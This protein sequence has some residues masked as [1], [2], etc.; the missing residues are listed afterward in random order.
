MT[1]AR[2]NKIPIWGGFECS[3]V[4]IGEEYRDQLGETGHGAREKDLDILPRLGLKTV[5]HGILWEHVAPDEPGQ[6]NWQ[7]SDTRLRILASRGITPIVGLLHHGSGP[8]YTHLLDPDFPQRLA[9]YARSV[10]RRYP[11]LTKFT[12][13]NEPGTTARFSCLYGHWFPHRRDTAAFLRALFLQVYG[14]ALAMRAIREITPAAE[15]IQT[16]E[17]GRVFSTPRLNYQAA[18]ENERRWLSLDLLCGRVDRAHGWH[19][20]FRTAGIAA[21]FL[22]DLVK[23]PSPPNIVGINYYLSSDRFLDHRVG[24]YPA[25]CRGGNGRHTYVDSEAIRAPE[26][27]ADSNLTERLLE[28]WARYNIPV[29]V[30]E[31]H[32]GCTRE[33]QIRWLVDSYRA[34]ERAQMLGVD[35]RGV[36]VW[37]LAGAVDWNSLLT[38]RASCYE[39]GVLEVSG[40]PVRITAM[41]RA[42]RELA[43]SGSYQHHLLD[44]P[45]WW[46]RQ[47]RFNK[48]PV[49]A[50]ETIPG[51]PL[52]VVGPDGAL[53]QAFA[54]LCHLRNLP[55]RL[56][57]PQEIDLV[58][59]KAVDGMIE[60]ERP[61]AIV[62]ITG[63]DQLFQN[64]AA[65]AAEILARASC[66]RSVPLVTFSS[67]Q[68]FDGRLGRPYIETD[69]TTPANEYGAGIVS[70]E[71]RV[72]ECHPMGMIV[73]TS[74]FFGPWN[75]HNFVHSVL[76]TLKAGRPVFIAADA[77]ISPTYLPDLV[78]RTLDLLIDGETG[79]WH[80]ASDSIT[81]WSELGR[82]VASRAGLDKSLVRS[83]AHTGINTSLASIRGMALPPLEGALTHYLA[84]QSAI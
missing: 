66:R 29:A 22:D 23:H 12:P 63:E 68:V 42:V 73:R 16:E 50:P 62:N 26:A 13:V 3:I 8:R 38:R 76:R 51:R 70:A 53:R 54:K 9:D 81:S 1:L 39:S 43:C 69:M 71:R 79:L 49:A 21:H 59:E 47:I 83:A 7:S 78:N 11:W 19:R 2:R 82:K 18:Y 44:N 24:R 60:R 74:P 67:D 33:E 5:R 72:T 27:A 10:A 25:E 32:N 40:N 20:A 55:F 64:D 30:T 36:T 80:L 75:S 28:V 4:R 34:A 61:W 84:H 15:L 45:G 14:V 37:S 77:Q 31:V 41:A 56:R 65:R 46:R 52:L 58:N 17:V 57:T 6:Y 48:D 35:I